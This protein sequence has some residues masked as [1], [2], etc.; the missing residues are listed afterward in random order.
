M[1][2]SGLHSTQSRPSKAT[3]S[4]EAVRL[5]GQKKPRAQVPIYDAAKNHEGVALVCGGSAGALC[6]ERQANAG[7]QVTI[8]HGRLVWEKPC[9][10]GSNEAVEV[11]S[12]PQDRSGCSRASTNPEA[13]F[14][15]EI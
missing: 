9:G 10:G 3:C 8:Y 2:V 6:G 7:F 12:L 11:Q 5:T 13:S 15:L 14:T 4:Q 1:V